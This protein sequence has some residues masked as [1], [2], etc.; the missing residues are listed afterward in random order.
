MS[1]NTLIEQPVTVRRSTVLD[2]AALTRLATLDSRLVPTGELVVAEVDGELWAAVSASGEAIADPFR[3][4]AHLVS[5][6][7]LR[8]RQLALGGPAS[9]RRAGIV[10]RALRHRRWRTLALR[11]AV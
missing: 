11:R 8:A 6:L 4:T 9:E 5:L 1:T 3:P 7:T 10:V 2:Q